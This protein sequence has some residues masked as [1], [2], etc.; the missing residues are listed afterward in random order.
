MRLNDRI[1]AVDD[2]QDNLTILEELLAEDYTLMCVSS[3]EEAVKM[4]P[5][6]K[7]D[8]VLLDVMMPGIDGIDTCRALQAVPELKGSRIVMLSAKSK[9]PDRLAAYDVGAVDYIAKPFDHYEVM[10]KIRAWMQMIHR[11]QVEEI[12]RAADK[13]EAVVGAAMLNLASLRDTETGDHLFRVRWYAQTL[14]EE[15]AMNGPYRALVDSTFRDCLYRASP[16]HDVGKIAIDDAILRKPGPLT[17]KEFETIK[18]HTVVGSELLR[19]AFRKMPTAKY[20]EM[21]ADIARH[22]HE[23]F[24]GSGYPDG[25]IGQRI[26]LA[27]RILAVADVFDALTSKRVYKDAI[28]T[29][30]AAGMM[31]SGAATQF[32]PVIVKAFDGRFDAICQAHTRFAAHCGTYD[33]ALTPFR[34]HLD[35]AGRPAWLVEKP[36]ERP[37]ELA[38]EQIVS[39]P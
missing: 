36:R 38:S 3:G 16:L 34:A 25:L 20:L 33:G 27:A 11:E 8:L 30:E 13:A 4:A 31:G 26:P 24:D 6:F 18:T 32:D 22:H 2:N 7:P 17:A 14:A 10:S 19:A 28:S 37:N 15:L 21:A 1:L 23:R 39:H 9:L 35:S 29:W 5:L 12:W